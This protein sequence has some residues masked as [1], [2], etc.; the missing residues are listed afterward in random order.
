MAIMDTE[1]NNVT[2]AKP[3]DLVGDRTK[4]IIIEGFGCLAVVVILTVC[5]VVYCW[6]KNNRHGS[7]NYKDVERQ[8]GTYTVLT[9]SGVYF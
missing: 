5:L 8:K 7:N 2:T 6:W 3:P 4:W 1:K 9:L